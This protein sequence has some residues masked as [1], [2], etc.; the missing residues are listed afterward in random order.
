LNNF[1]YIKNIADGEGT[2]C[3]YSQIGD[4]IDADGNYQIGISGSA[5]ANELLW[6]Q[7]NCSLINVRIN[8]IGGSV[9]DGYSIVSAILS[10][11]VPV[12]TYIDGLAASIAG[13]IAVAGKKCYM[14]D[15]GTLMVHNPSGGDDKNVLSLIKD[16]LVTILTNRSGCTPEEMDQMMNK[17][18]WLNAKQAQEKGLVDE[19]ISSGKKVK[20][21]KKESLEN[22]VLIYNKVINT[23]KKMDKVTNLLKLSNDAS[24]DSV[25]SAIEALNAEKA[26]LAE[27]N[28]ALK[29]ELEAYK[30]EK[31]EKEKSEKE[32]LETEAAALVNKAEAD[33]KI[34][35]EEKA[36]YLKQASA[37]R[38]GLEFVKNVFDKISNVKQAE[39]IFKGS[40]GVV[41]KGE[42]ADWT[43]RDWEKKDPKGLAELKNSTPELYQDMYNAFYKK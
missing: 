18:T 23:D 20:I 11:K 36:A 38:E 17:E 22:M 25:V 37:S 24:E 16:T 21:K 41:N 15:Y 6:L 1:R 7:Q 34:K 3:L 10:S 14:M 9:I 30:K 4:S 29:N 28:E 32:S 5:F 35:A 27:E 42:R 8:S 19:I 40:T 12:N 31:E 2:I 33:K 43:I 39:K 13:V 26:K